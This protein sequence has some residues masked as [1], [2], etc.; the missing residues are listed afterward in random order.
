VVVV[1]VKCFYPFTLWKM[2]PKILWD[3]PVVFS[4]F[5]ILAHQV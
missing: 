1:K 2:G 5:G 4:H 3:M